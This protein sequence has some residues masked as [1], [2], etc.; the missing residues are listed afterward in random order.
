MATG[1]PTTLALRTA[2]AAKAYGRTAAYDAAISD[3][4]AT[5]LNDTSPEWRALGGQLAQ[6]LRHGESPRQTAAL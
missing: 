1:G 4:F 3:W 6:P 5:V 2:L